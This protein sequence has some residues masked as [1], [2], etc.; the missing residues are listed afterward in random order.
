MRIVKSH[1]VDS[2][3]LI[4]GR[5]RVVEFSCTTSKYWLGQNH[6]IEPEHEIH[7]GWQGAIEVNAPLPYRS[8]SRKVR[9]LMRADSNSYKLVAL[10]CKE[11]PSISNSYQSNLG[12]ETT[13]K[14][15]LDKQ[16]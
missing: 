15:S 8:R 7:Q 14:K 10:F 4:M 9:H 2:W 12:F 13:M 1:D 5:D 16:R 11:F 3:G 6:E